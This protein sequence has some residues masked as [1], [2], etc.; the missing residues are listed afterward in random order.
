[1]CGIAGILVKPNNSLPDLQDRLGAMARVMTHRGPDDE[2]IYVSSDERVGLVNRRLAIRDL[3]AAAHMPMGNSEGSVWITYNG[4]IYNATE[5]RA[6]LEDQ[7]Y[8]FRSHSDTEV[9][10]HGY[11]AWGQDVVTRLRGMFALAVLDERGRGQARLLLARDHLGIKPLYYAQTGQGF[12]FAS[13]LKALLASGL[14]S[15]EV[16]P[17]GLVGYLHLGSVPNPLTIYRD[18]QAL[19]PASCLALD[20]G[21]PDEGATQ[22]Y[23]HLPVDEGPP[24]KYEEAVAQVQALLAESVRIRLVSDVPLG[25]FL[26]GGLDSSSVVALMRQATSGPIRTCSMAFEEADFSEAPYARAVAE[27]VG[28]DHHERVITAQDVLAE[29]DTIL[30]ALDQPSIDG[31]NTYFVSQTARPACLAVALSGLGGDELFGGYPNTF[32][33]APRIA[34]AIRLLQTVPGAPALAQSALSRM[35]QPHRWARLAD[36]VTQ[37]A[38]MAGAYLTRLVL[39]Q[40]SAGTGRA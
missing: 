36:A 10:L 17:G 38:S 32:Y 40:S 37:P 2:G 8:R 15:R 3:S 26:S 11:Q 1:M 35:P 7:G 24:L 27:K 18:V 39:S 28:S 14:V 30:D 20:C 6:A 13:E 12:I 23:W 25:A 21:R 33:E 22:T 9:V 16:S 31:V 34:R 29:L 19:P 5:L 4:E